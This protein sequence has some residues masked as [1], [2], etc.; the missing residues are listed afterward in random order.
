MSLEATVSSQIRA[1][2]NRNLYSYTLKNITICRILI[3]IVVINKHFFKLEIS[4]K[5]NFKNLHNILHVNDNIF[6]QYIVV[7]I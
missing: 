5:I 6:V 4:F 7:Q 1:I 3:F 2:V